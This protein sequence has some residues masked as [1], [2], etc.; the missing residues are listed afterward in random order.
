MKHMGKI[1]LSD[2]HANLVALEAVLKD[3]DSKFFGA[4]KFFLGDAVDKTSWPKEC[5]DI[6]R[7]ECYVMLLGNHDK[8]ALAVPPYDHTTA[9]EPAK[10]ARIIMYRSFYSLEESDR[11]FI[12]SLPSQFVFNN[13]VFAHAR[14]TKGDAL[15][16]NDCR[17]EEDKKRLN[18][19]VTSSLYDP[20]NPGGMLYDRSMTDSGKKIAVG[21]V[22]Y[23]YLIGLDGKVTLPAANKGYKLK[24]IAVIG[25][26]SISDSRD[27]NKDAGY[28]LIDDWEVR[29]FRTAFDY[30]KSKKMLPVVVRSSLK[31]RF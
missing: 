24:D 2:T 13:L 21:H 20:S 7:K 1:I 26:P 31:R 15:S 25:V 22:H 9:V 3:I 5:L 8:T 4:K 12:K 28:V 30:E 23:S 6:L 14:P 16:F 10:K 18:E 11:E 17:T 29:F 19:R 27:G